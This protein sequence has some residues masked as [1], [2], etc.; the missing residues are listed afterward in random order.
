MSI[1]VWTACQN[2]ECEAYQE[3]R[4]VE[5][6]W[7]EGV[8]GVRMRTVQLPVECESCGTEGVAILIEESR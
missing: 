6:D 4:A 2:D 8:E 1:K 7:A 5:T 3:P